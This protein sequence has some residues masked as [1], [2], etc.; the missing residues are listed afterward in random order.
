ML[1]I[2]GQDQTVWQWIQEQLPRYLENPSSLHPTL[3]G[4]VLTLGATRGDEKLFEEYRKRFENATLPTER[5]RFLAGLGRFRDP[6]LKA[7]A[8]EYALTG[9]VRP[10][11]LFVLF[12][13]G[14]TPEEHDEMFNW[15]LANFD[16]ITKKLPPAFASGMVG[17][18]GGCEP[19]RV[20]KA[21]EFFGPRN[22]PNA[23]RRLAQ[24]EEQVKEC[25][26]LRAREM[27]S[28]TGYLKK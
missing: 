5:S 17:I 10:N 14:D 22:I 18:A 3:V 13:G 26:A 11:E 2:Y 6:A 1:A 8:R 15:V 9:P 7:R 21:R 16:A 12:G 24:V 4:T 27:E 25:A 19:A 23:E 20:A 28:V